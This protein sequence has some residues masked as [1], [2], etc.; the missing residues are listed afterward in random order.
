MLLRIVIV[1]TALLSS[2]LIFAPTL[3]GQVAVGPERL[4][5]RDDLHAAALVQTNPAAASDGS[6]WLVVWTSGPY[7][8]GVSIAATRV[9]PGGNVVD[10]SPIVIADGGVRSAAVAFGVDRYLVAWT[11][12]DSVRVRLVGRDG[13]LS[14][15]VE[16]A[17]IPAS[18]VGAEIRAAWDGNRF[19][20]AWTYTLDYATV[21]GSGVLL[22]SHGAVVASTPLFEGTRWYD[23]GIA[24]GDGEFLV[25]YPV[26]DLDGKPSP[27]GYPSS[28]LAL[29]VNDAG[30]HAAPIVIESATTPVFAPRAAFNGRDY[31]M[32]WS[33]NAQVPGQAR[34]ARLSG[35]G[36]VT[37]IA[38]FYSGDETV[39]SLTWTGTGYIVTLSG[40]DHVDALRLDA[41]TST[42]S[43]LQSLFATTTGLP[44]QSQAAWN[45][46]TLLVAIDTPG[47]IYERFLDEG[48]TLTDPAIG[49]S[50]NDL[51]DPNRDGLPVAL[52]PAQEVTPSIASAGAG[53]SLMV[54]SEKNTAVESTVA[55]A[56]VLREG[57][58]T[59]EPPLVLGSDFKPPAVASDGT[60][61]LVV[62]A[63]A[64]RGVVGRRL[65]RN[66]SPIDA[67]SF[68]ISSAGGQFSP[69]AVVYDGENFVVAYEIGGG[70]TNSV[71]LTQ[72]ATRVS[73][74]GVVLG[75][76]I[77][78]GGRACGPKLS[79]ASGPSGSLLAWEGRDGPAVALITRG[80]TTA[81]AINLS[82]MLSGRQIR[83]AWTGTEFIVAGVIAD[84]EQPA[85]GV[86]WLTL[87]A[88]G[89]PKSHGFVRE[90]VATVEV[91]SSAF[92]IFGNGA[93]FV[94]STGRFGAHDVFGL[95][96][97]GEGT[98]VGDPFPI[99]ATEFDEAS[100]AVTQDRNGRA[101]VTYQRTVDFPGVPGL[102]R[103]FTREVRLLLP[104]PRR[105]ASR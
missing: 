43:P 54:W 59:S 16:I 100:V 61:Y 75:P 32:I 70:C 58:A 88:D 67:E 52:S 95:L 9:D 12:R 33:S 21:R 41:A 102:T 91:D 82:S 35:E 29:R 63:E 98:A 87:T 53:E 46:R 28:V 47:D 99:A 85:A 19:L 57:V 74:A 56:R 72:A 71:S 11:E 77:V 10:Q 27:N 34:G 89:T 24:A 15:T 101:Q 90:P 86:E 73:P 45:G 92:T 23:F 76:M 80:G 42:A 40:P 65:A 8:P 68:V 69:P 4:L 79:F 60:Q 96:L 66:G 25:I 94:W 55:M 17:S 48:A 50:R 6:G 93:L 78:I 64:Y 14:P 44:P 7:Q 38:P 81:G 3:F 13:V 22:D 20:V 83:A 37:P 30:R 84:S 36:A 104:G 97:S 51:L 18:T 26:V 2:F 1:R 103:V 105:R 39:D 31:V 5:N 49:S 62:W